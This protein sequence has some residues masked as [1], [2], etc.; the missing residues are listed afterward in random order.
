V[1]APRH[2]AVA[3]PADV[4]HARREA[5]RLATALGFDVADAERVALAVSELG[6]NRTRY[7]RYGAI[8]LSRVVGPHGTGVQVESRDAGPGIAD[9]GQA[10]ADG[11]SS[12][13]GLGGGLP[14]VRRLMDDFHIATGPGGTTIVACKWSSNR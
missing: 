6:T 7:A 8:V 5:R 10:M 9:V 4:E 13:G 12:G 2:F 3:G 1:Q 11:F 14:A